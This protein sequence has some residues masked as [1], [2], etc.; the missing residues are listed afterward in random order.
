MDTQRPQRGQTAEI[1]F[2]ARSHIGTSPR[3]TLLEDRSRADRISTASGLD[4]TLAV[5]ADGP[6]IPAPCGICR[7]FLAEFGQDLQL[8]LANRQGQLKRVKLQELLP[9]A[10]TGEHLRC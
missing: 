1:Y 2:A 3:R 5:V 6:S 8:V 4:M 7:Q 10:F 9:G